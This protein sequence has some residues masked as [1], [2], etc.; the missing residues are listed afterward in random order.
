MQLLAES[1]RENTSLRS[2]NV[3]FNQIGDDGA[4]GIAKMLQ[5]QV[6]KNSGTAYVGAITHLKMQ[7]NSISSL[8]M[9]PLFNALTPKS[10]R[11]STTLVKQYLLNLELHKNSFNDDVTQYFC[12]FLETNKTLKTLKI[13]SHCALNDKSNI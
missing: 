3:A 6:K 1:L 2:L 9:I 10:T 5:S 12:K 13:G 4:A 7:G 8:G 11:G